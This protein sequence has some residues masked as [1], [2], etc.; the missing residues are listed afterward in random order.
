MIFADHT[1]LPFER[2]AECFGDACLLFLLWLLLV[3]VCLQVCSEAS[4][5]AAQPSVDADLATV[6]VLQLLPIH[7][8]SFV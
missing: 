3:A 7:I 5:L 1:V 4:A 6:A 2:A 8:S